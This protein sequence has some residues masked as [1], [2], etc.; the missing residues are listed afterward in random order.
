MS[1]INFEALKRQFPEIKNK[2]IRL[3]Y[4]STKENNYFNVVVYGKYNHGK[5][6]LL[7]ALIG[8]E[9][10][11]KVED[12]R[13]TTKND[14]F[15]DGLK[16]IKW[17]DT[18]GL[19]ADIQGN[20]DTH[21]TNA[22]TK[23]ADI[24]LFVHSLRM[25]ELD[26][27]EMEYLKDLVYLKPASSLILVLTQQDQTRAEQFETVYGCI[28]KQVEQ[29]NLKNI[30]VSTTRYFKGLS[31][32]NGNQIARSKI[33]VL[34]D[35]LM[36]VYKENDYLDTELKNLTKEVIHYLENEREIVEQNKV[37][38]QQELRQMH[39]NFQNEV[40]QMINKIQQFY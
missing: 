20:D 17:I 8:D 16:G 29:F 19:S 5:S 28:E 33:L 6:S 3:E 35:M 24:I 13:T 12:C 4:L 30:C 9:S 2:I 25:G 11:F 7:N 10:I 38:K 34:Q 27:A 32:N 1:N 31:L 23:E 40:K 39:S 26:Q 22:I 15:I 37:K 14:S 36:Q 18:P 21:A